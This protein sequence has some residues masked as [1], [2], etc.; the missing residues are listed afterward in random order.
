VKETVVLGYKHLRKE[1]GGILKGHGGGKTI[2][3]GRE[4]LVR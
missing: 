4:E 1:Y 3:Y 2:A